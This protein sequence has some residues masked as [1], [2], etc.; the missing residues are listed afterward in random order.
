MKWKK[1]PGK[2]VDPMIKVPV[3]HVCGRCHNTTVDEEGELC[4]P[5][6]RRRKRVAR[7]VKERDKEYLAAY[8]KHKLYKGVADG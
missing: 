1:A 2:K 8:R 4:P 5:C 6:E 3:I 7:D